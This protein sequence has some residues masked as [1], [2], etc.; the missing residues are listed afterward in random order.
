MKEVL[1]RLL[2]L[3]NQLWNHLKKISSNSVLLCRHWTID[4][5]LY[6]FPDKC[7]PNN[8]IREIFLPENSYMDVAFLLDNSRTITNNEFKAVKALVSSMVDNFDVASEPII[9]NFG[10]RIAL[11]SYSPWDSSR[12][13]KGVVKTEFQF[14]TYNNQVLMKRHIQTSLQQLK[15]D[16]TIGQTLLW[17]MENL[18][19][20]T[21]N[22]RK[23]KV[24]FVI[25]AGEYHERKDFLK[26]VALRAKC[27][28]YVIFVISLGS[29]HK[30]DIEELASYPLDHHLIQLGKIHK[31]DL[32]YVTKF[33]KPFIYSVRR[34]SLFCFSSLF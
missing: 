29:A 23:H 9:S 7:F 5:S 4:K 22:L 34:K 21:P 12:R 25:S 2:I 28:G 6:V 19:A 24:I 18:F 13:R 31:P 17:T 30:D 14:N 26:K 15:G 8:C 3:G 1:I 33:L 16:A 20:Q 32:D 11:L 27:Q 10:D